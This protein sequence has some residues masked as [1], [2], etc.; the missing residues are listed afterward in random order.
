MVWQVELT[1]AVGNKAAKDAMKKKKKEEEEE[2]KKNLPE[3]LLERLR[4]EG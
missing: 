3:A 2:K 1:G 4:E